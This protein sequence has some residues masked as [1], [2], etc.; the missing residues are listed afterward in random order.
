ARALLLLK[1]SP[2]ASLG[3]PTTQSPLAKAAQEDL[4]A[5]PPQVRTARF[6]GCWSRSS[7]PGH[8][9]IVPGPVADLR[10]VLAALANILLMLH[11]FVAQ[12]LLEVRA[13]PLQARD[14]IHHVARQVIAVEIVQY[15]HVKRRGRGSLFL[16][17]ADVHVVVIVPAIREP[18]NQPGIT[19]V[20]EDDRLIHGEQRIEIVVGKSVRMFRARLN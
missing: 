3:Q 14:T 5:D 20:G 7:G 1:C 12:E 13:G 16:V 9:S 11:E 10:H 8:A 4:W 19:V 6:S 2:Q 17:T 15:R 18:V